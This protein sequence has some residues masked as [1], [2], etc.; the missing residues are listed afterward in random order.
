MP[1]FISSLEQCKGKY[2]AL[3]DGDDYWI[4]ENKLQKQVDF[5]ENNI[6]FSLVHTGVYGRKEDIIIKTLPLKKWNYIKDE[7][8]LKE[9]LYLPIAFTSTSLFRNTKL[10]PKIKD[11]LLQLT[12]GDWGIW[13]YV[14]LNGKAKFINYP[15]AVYRMNVG[16]SKDLNW[17]SNYLKRGFYLF[18][19]MKLANSFNDK[20][21]ILVSICYYILIYFKLKYIAKK[22]KPQL[23]F[24]P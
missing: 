19:V 17:E 16:V 9:S 10:T 15:S 3:C 13:I 24:K 12:S 11:K 14:L 21:N 5:L 23:M 2:V 6:E 22:I 4:D 20:K 8:S 1:N 7:L 18:F